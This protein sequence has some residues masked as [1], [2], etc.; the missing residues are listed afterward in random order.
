MCEMPSYQ[1]AKL[2]WIIGND[3]RLPG[4]S[5]ASLSRICLQAP[6]MQRL[7]KNKNLSVAV[8]KSITRH[9]SRSLSGV[10]THANIQ[11]AEALYNGWRACGKQQR[12]PT[13]ISA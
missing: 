13:H 8:T 7:R 9:I 5:T 1:K 2:T 11:A 4:A 10:L 12:S 3:M 6:V